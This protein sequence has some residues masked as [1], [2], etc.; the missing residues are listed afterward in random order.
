[1]PSARRLLQKDQDVTLVTLLSNDARP[2]V[3]LDAPLSMTIVLELTAAA[4]FDFVAA[5]LLA[6]NATLQTGFTE[7]HLHAEAMRQ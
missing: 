4:G 1:M 7:P 6:E 2:M 5:G 3:P